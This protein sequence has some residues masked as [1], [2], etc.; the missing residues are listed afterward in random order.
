MGLA[1]ELG[2]FKYILEQDFSVNNPL[3][4]DCKCD[5]ITLH[6]LMWAY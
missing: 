6:M 3:I 4:N 2:W 5:G 1:K